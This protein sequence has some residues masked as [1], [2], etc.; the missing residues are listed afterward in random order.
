MRK[1]ALLAD[2]PQPR[3]TRIARVAKI[4]DTDVV[5]GRVMAN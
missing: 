3:D 5:S 4:A 2:W 1:L